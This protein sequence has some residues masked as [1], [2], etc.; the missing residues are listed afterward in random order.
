MTLQNSLHEIVIALAGAIQ[1]ISVV[2][3]LAKTGYLRT[4]EYETAVNSLFV[5]DPDA[6]ADVFGRPENLSFGFETLTE[7]LNN[8]RDPKNSDLLRYV[9]GAMHL[10]KRLSRRSDM[11][12]V[13][14]NR[15][16]KA[17]SQAQ[18]FGVS[19]EN[20]ASNLAEIYTDTVSKFSYRIQISGEYGYLQQA[21]VANQIRTLLLA[22]IRAFTLWRQVGGGRLQIIFKRGKL[23]E[24][25]SQ[26]NDQ[27]RKTVH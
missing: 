9:L 12:Y 13:I 27:Y 20:V 25:A 21:R 6:A 19:H 11:L 5:R 4:E 23:A 15:L 10:Q 16:E 3:Q 1:A 17:Q 18:H 14:S 2:E 22:A 26:L 7:L 24:I 8:H